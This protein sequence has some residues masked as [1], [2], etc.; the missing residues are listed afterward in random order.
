M[1]RYLTLVTLTDKGVREIKN[2]ASRA[3]AFADDVRAAGGTVIG[4]YWAV[5]Q[6]D[7]AVI[8]DA[9]DEDI[10]TSLLLKLAHEGYV[11]TQ[12]QRIFTAEEFQTV[13][14]K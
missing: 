7:G 6:Y 2:S 1:V 13:L 8:F 10:S 3:A 11:R 4:Q 9:P 5:G 12:S 14:T